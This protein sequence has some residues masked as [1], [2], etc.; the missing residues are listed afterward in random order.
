[1]QVTRLLLTLAVA[2]TSAVGARADDPT[3]DAASTSRYV[4]GLT[5]ISAPEYA[6][7][8]KRDLKLRPL[9]AYQYGRYRIS[10][11]R[12]S[13]ALGF[14]S[15]TQGPGA[16]A[17]LVQTDHLKFG[18]ALRF[19][20][21]RKS[22]D[23]EH[24]SGLP[25]I[26]RT[27]RGRVYAGYTLSEHWDLSGNVSADLLGRKGGTLG[28]VDLGY[29]QRIGEHSEWSTGGGL[30]VAN[31]QNMRTYFGITP[32]QAPLAHLPVFTPG[33]GVRDF[34]TGVGLTTALTPSWIAF[35]NLTASRLSG[36]AANSPL[37]KDKNSLSAGIGL[38]YRCCKW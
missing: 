30:T 8:D 35:A 31:G 14:A 36:D 13:S 37:S 20:S 19:D 28:S 6:G 32:E 16:S 38:A 1:M 27:L 10:T 21:G 29:H 4:L 26:A 18:A 25:N 9:W 22:A 23:S 34:H 24:L 7:S 12:A 3:E 11:S 15:D 5:A 17:L 33:A 2:L